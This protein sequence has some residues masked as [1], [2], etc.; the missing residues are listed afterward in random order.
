ML[1]DFIEAAA[2]SG[3]NAEAVAAVDRFSPRATAGNARL[4]WPAAT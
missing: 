2:R 1:V 3:H 4:S